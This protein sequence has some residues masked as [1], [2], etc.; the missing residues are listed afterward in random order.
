MKKTSDKDIPFRPKR[1]KDLTDERAF[2]MIRLLLEKGYAQTEIADLTM[3]RQ[4]YQFTISETAVMIE[5]EDLQKN[6]DRKGG[7][8]PCKD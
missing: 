7:D 6:A 2:E 1:R 4:K 5:A 8:P 3:S